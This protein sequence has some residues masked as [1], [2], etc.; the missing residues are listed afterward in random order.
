[1]MQEE[2]DG[3]VARTSDDR[4]MHPKFLALF[5]KERISS[6]H[7]TKQGQNATDDGVICLP[8]AF[9]ADPDIQFSVLRTHS[10]GPSFGPSLHGFINQCGMNGRSSADPS[11]GRSLSTRALLGD[12][13]ALCSDGPAGHK[14][15]ACANVQE[16]K[17]YPN[18]P[19]DGEKT[20]EDRGVETPTPIP[21]GRKGRGKTILLELSRFNRTMGSFVPQVLFPAR[22]PSPGLPQL[23]QRSQTI[24]ED[25]EDYI[26]DVLGCSAGI[27]I[28]F[29]NDYRAGM[30][31]ARTRLLH[32]FGPT[33]L[34][35]SMGILHRVIE[36]APDDPNEASFLG[37]WARWK[38]PHAHRNA[39]EALSW[40]LVDCA[41][42]LEG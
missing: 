11:L 5:H 9:E 18:T 19:L 26:I 31:L 8:R 7:R 10:R 15:V 14:P 28:E 16:A 21:G 20:D 12:D 33:Q 27:P 42:E 34:S 37:V 2:A 38:Y 13:I 22:V 29:Q 35:R 17:P 23:L 24:D 4:W 36:D 41:D 25:I 32:Q 30:R 3:T 6:S 1:M 40:W 39:S